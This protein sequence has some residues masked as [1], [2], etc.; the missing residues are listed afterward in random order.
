MRKLLSFLLALTLLCGLKISAAAARINVTSHAQMLK[1]GETVVITLSLDEDIPAE[2]GATVLQGE[3]SYNSEVLEFRQVEKCSADLTDA[4]KHSGKDMVVFHY[5]SSDG[6]AKEFAAGELLRITFSA[7]QDIQADHAYAEITFRAQ[8]QNAL[9]ETVAGLTYDPNLTVII[10][11]EHDWA[12]ATYSRP[13]MCRVCNAEEGEPLGLPVPAVTAGA[14]EGGKLTLSW[15]AVEEA[16]VYKVYRA[17]KKNGRFEQIAATGENIY[18]DASA[19]IGTTYYYQVQACC[20]RDA[21]VDSPNSTAVSGTATCAVPEITVER[22]AASGKPEICWGAAE[23]AK[24]YDVYRAD[25]P[26]GKFKKIKT[27]SALSYM[28]TSAK[29]GMEYFYRVSAVAAKAAGNSALSNMGSC[30]AVCGQPVVSAQLDAKTGLPVLSWKAVKDAKSYEIYRSSGAGGEELLVTQSAVKYSDK[31]AENDTVYTYRVRAI[32]K[33]E[34]GN[35]EFSEELKAVTA[36]AMPVI[37]AVTTEEI[38]GCP[39][40]TWAAVEKAQRYEITRAVKKNGPYTC[41]DS[42]D[43]LSFVDE[44]AVGGTTYFYKIAAVGANSIST[45]SD[46]K[47]ICARYP[48]PVIMVERNDA[49][50]KPEAAWNAVEGAKKYDVYRAESADGAFKKVKTVT[51]VSYIDT[52]AKTGKEYFYKVCAVASSKAGNSILSEASA[53][54][55]AVCGQP[56][57]TVKLDEKTGT[58]PTLTWKKVSDAVAYGIWRSEVGGESVLLSTQTAVKYIDKTA[59]P[60]TV[61]QYF[62]NAIAKDPVNNSVETA[63]VI[64]QT[65]CAMPVIRTV[66]ND[67]VSGRPVVAWDAVEGAARYEIFRST[68]AKKDYISVGFSEELSFMDENAVAGTKCY[69]TV[70]ATGYNGSI[71]AVS[72]N[73]SITCR[74]AQPKAVL[75]VSEDGGIVISWDAVDGAKKYTVY[76]AAKIDGKYS[77]VKTVTELSYTDTKAKA[78]VTYYYKVVA[79]GSGSAANSSYSDAVTNGQE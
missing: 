75:E 43:A 32:S 27:V 50:G 72:A 65:T 35:G 20:S 64:L 45:G 2:D 9:G 30:R 8:V 57:V 5:L 60:D 63:P 24:K 58:Q 11:K 76:R 7:K 68:N 21:S 61:Y 25:S 54:C 1:P 37:S 47:S 55:S 28:D 49:A 66:S 13:R 33:G 31:T 70:V 17:V 18:V 34:N 38:S 44:T 23:G 53:G 14:G 36:C 74:C 3:L 77:S 71:S 56:Q 79:V 26:D 4:A 52:S 40:I 73:K 42:T 29:T 6:S 69:Y 16:D 46:C 67:P 78:G 12:E 59:A 19:E 15:D 41:I 51:A 22:N 62:V 39:V 10:A 48:Q